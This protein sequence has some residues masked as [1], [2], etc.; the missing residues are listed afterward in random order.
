MLFL[1]TIGCAVAYV[2]QGILQIPNCNEQILIESVDSQAN[3]VQL[4]N[5]EQPEYLPFRLS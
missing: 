5:D 1:V 4:S 2:T 3:R